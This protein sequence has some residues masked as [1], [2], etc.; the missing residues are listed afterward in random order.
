MPED[1]N[2]SRLI[3]EERERLAVA[4]IDSEVANQALVDTA[5]KLADPQR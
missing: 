3:T 5:R 1:G 2:V 4:Q